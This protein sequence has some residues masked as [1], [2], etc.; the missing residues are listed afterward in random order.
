MAFGFLLTQCLQNLF[1]C[2]ST[3]TR[4]LTGTAALATLLPAFATTA[5]LTTA[6]VYATRFLSSLP[7]GPG[8]WSAGSASSLGIGIESRVILRR[9]SG[10]RFL[11]PSRQDAGQFVAFFRH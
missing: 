10:F 7:T 6:F 1:G 9:D 11:L 3:T 5:F 4:L 8:S 2:W